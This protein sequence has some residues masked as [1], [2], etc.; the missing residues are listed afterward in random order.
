MTPPDRPNLQR[1]IDFVAPTRYCE[2]D[3]SERGN[4]AVLEIRGPEVECRKA[5]KYIKYSARGLC[6]DG[7]SLGRESSGI[8]WVGVRGIRSCCAARYSTTTPLIARRRRPP[9]AADDLYLSNKCSPPRR[10]PFRSEQWSHA[11]TEARG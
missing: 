8:V 1:G 3:L 6:L 11:L 4:E 5:K 9:A 2:L 7:V 10:V